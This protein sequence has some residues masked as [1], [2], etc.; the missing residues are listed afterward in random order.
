MGGLLAFTTAI[1]AGYFT[2]TPAPGPERVSALFT[3]IE[4]AGLGITLLGFV[5]G[6]Y[7]KACLRAVR[8]SATYLIQSSDNPLTTGELTDLPFEKHSICAELIVS[9]GWLEEALRGIPGIAHGKPR[10]GQL[11]W[12]IAS[13]SL[14][15]PLADTTGPT[16]NGAARKNQPAIRRSRVAEVWLIGRR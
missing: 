7:G 4:L 2:L 15:P 3:G 13:A 9:E 16:G 6:A 14:C 10:A 1:S 12:R 5:H 11:T 8:R